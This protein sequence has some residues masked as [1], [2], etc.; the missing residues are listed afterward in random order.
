[1]SVGEAMRQQAPNQKMMPDLAGA[2]IKVT[3]LPKQNPYWWI[4]IALIPAI[5]FLYNVVT[6]G[7]VIK[8]TERYFNALYHRKWDKAASL[9]SKADQEIKVRKEFLQEYRTC[10]FGSIRDDRARIRCEPL[11]SKTVGGITYLRVRLME[12]GGQSKFS[13]IKWIRLVRSWA[14][15]QIYYGWLVMQEIDYRYYFEQYG[16]Y[17]VPPDEVPPPE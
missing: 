7:D 8:V 17:R 6:Y 9:L 10:T 5:W 13:T 16:E 15:W 14:R 3:Y 4:V 2:G 12:E 11:A 1:M